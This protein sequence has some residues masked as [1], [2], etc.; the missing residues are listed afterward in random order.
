MDGWTNGR[1][2]EWTN[3]RMDGWTN[4]RMDAW[5]RLGGD[6]GGG[7]FFLNACTAASLLSGWSR[8]AGS[9]PYTLSCHMV[10]LLPPPAPALFLPLLLPPPLPKPVKK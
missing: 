1:M 7:R 3:G 5:K 2:N 4:G 9:T 10:A 8:R 6:G